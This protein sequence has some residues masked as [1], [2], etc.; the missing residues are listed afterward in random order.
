[1]HIPRISPHA[2]TTS[3]PV[4]MHASVLVFADEVCD[5]FVAHDPRMVHKSRR[6]RPFH[7]LA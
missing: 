4:A 6:R 7:D 2:R 3:V 1:M 5:L